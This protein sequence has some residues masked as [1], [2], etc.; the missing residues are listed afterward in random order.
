MTTEP[1]EAWMQVGP[2]ARAYIAEK[3]AKINKRAAKIGSTG[4][5]VEYTGEINKYRECDSSGNYLYTITYEK[6]LI[7]GAPPRIAGWEFVA[8]LEHL[9]S[10]NMIYSVPGTNCPAEY[11]KADSNC[12][13]CRTKRL[14]K[15]TFVV[16]DADGNHK[17]VG[18]SC[19]R[20]FLGHDLPTGFDGIFRELADPDLAG[21]FRNTPEYEFSV[22]LPMVQSVVRTFGWLSKSKAEFDHGEATADRVYRLYFAKQDK[23]SQEALEQIGGITEADEASG[24]AAQDW[25]ANL[26]DDEV[27][28]SNYLL[29][30]RT[31]A[32]SETYTDRGFSLACSI[33]GAYKRATEKARER[34]SRPD[35][36]HV[37][38]IGKR[39]NFTVTCH[40]IFE[41]EGSFGVT[42][43]HKLTDQDG[44][45]MTWF[46]SGSAEWLDEGKTYEVKATVKKHDDYKGRS[47]TVINRVKI[48]KG[49]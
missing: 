25:A 29:N 49:N 47:Q 42:A 2:S 32:S 7:H 17:Q 38:E 16:R 18:S 34:T 37:G 9:D 30:L 33:I 21:G 46:A 15:D 43:I 13:H 40:R 24:K 5:T 45:D 31:L 11:Q 41:T 26:T 12:D 8:R 35:S 3:L 27:A 19:L 10:G 4:L 28:D 1:R 22:L 48:V 39:Q 44:N 14:R 23:Y 20:D 36:H 6:M